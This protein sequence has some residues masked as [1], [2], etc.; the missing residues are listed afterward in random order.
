VVY[1]TSSINSVLRITKGKI[2]GTGGAAELL[3]INASTLR[4]RMGKLGIKSG[5]KK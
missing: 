2:Y 4:G 3:G 5:R 1:G